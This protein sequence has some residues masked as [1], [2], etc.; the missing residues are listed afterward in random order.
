MHGE[1]SSGYLGHERAAWSPG[2]SVAA[3]LRIVLAPHIAFQAS[4]GAML[5]LRE[6]QVFIDGKEVARTGRPAWLG[7][8]LLEVTF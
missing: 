7:N 8:A 5:L 4:G 1:G 6:P 2:W 3:G